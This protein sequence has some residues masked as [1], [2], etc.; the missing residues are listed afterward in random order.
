MNSLLMLTLQLEFGTSF[1]GTT[2]T[3]IVFITTLLLVINNKKYVAKITDLT[4]LHTVVEERRQIYN[5]WLT[6]ALITSI[7][8]AIAIIYI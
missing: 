3:F 2:L 7:I 4:E 5:T 6:Y 1:I 8:A